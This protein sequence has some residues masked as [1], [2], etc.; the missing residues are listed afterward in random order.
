[1]I[2]HDSSWIP[3]Y[4]TRLISLIQSAIR[5]ISAVPALEARAMPLL[6]IPDGRLVIMDLWRDE[7]R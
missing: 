7:T 5:L 1:M 4:V 3:L 2:L 6:I